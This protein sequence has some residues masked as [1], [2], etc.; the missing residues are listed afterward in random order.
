MVVIAIEYAYYDSVKSANEVFIKLRENISTFE[1]EAYL[2]NEAKCYVANFETLDDF[3]I[4][5]GYAYQS[6]NGY[7]LIYDDIKLYVEL[8]GKMI[9]QINY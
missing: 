4:D 2:I 8:D 3:E 9:T 5:D 7:V 6:G 1:K